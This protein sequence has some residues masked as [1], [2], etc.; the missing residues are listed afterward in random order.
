MQDRPNSREL[1]E[2]VAAFLEQEIIP[3]TDDARLRFRA[4]IA[5]NVLAVVGR[6]LAAG[7]AP[8]YGEYERLTELLK[9][10]TESAG[11]QSGETWHAVIYTLSKILCAQIRAGDWDDP[12]D[13]ERALTH[14]QMTVVEKL[15]VSNPRYLKA[16]ARAD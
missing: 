5:A 8:I 4:L 16:F 3:A 11:S 2:A 1:I 12:A 6:E 15:R 10:P 14:A 13:F 7:E 9:V